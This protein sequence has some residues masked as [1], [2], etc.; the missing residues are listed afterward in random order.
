MGNKWIIIFFFKVSQVACGSYHTMIIVVDG[1]EQNESGN[2]YAWG[3]NN[4][5]RLGVPAKEQAPGGE[6]QKEMEPKIV[7][8]QT[9]E[10]ALRI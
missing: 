1:S 2:L 7:T 3:L 9:N 10:K 8:F 4:D 5:N 6:D